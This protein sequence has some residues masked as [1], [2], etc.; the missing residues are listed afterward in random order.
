MVRILRQDVKRLSELR[1]RR[2]YFRAG[3]IVVAVVLVLSVGSWVLA[4]DTF[5]IK[6]VKVVV[7]GGVPEDEVLK[8]V[9]E[10]ISGHYALVIPKSNVLFYP[11]LSIKDKINGQFARIGKI[12]TDV[13][14]QGSLEVKLREREE[15]YIWCASDVYEKRKSGKGIEGCFYIDDTALIFKE[16]PFFREGIFLELITNVPDEDGDYIGQYALESGLFKK[17]VSI[18]KEVNGPSISIIRVLMKE[19]GDIVLTTN[20][21]W[22]ILI[23]GSTELEKV[24]R[25][26]SVAL[27]SNALKAEVID[28]HGGLEYLDLRFG[29]KVFFKFKN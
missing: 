3:A 1:K 19:D 15:K 28:A 5:K 22:E 25:N 7:A 8:I 13:K 20:K 6:E 4:S 16:A 12:T 24:V 27:A 26:L 18:I 2:Q 17:I 9:Q 10:E 29:N 23:A 11:R 21:N 14:S